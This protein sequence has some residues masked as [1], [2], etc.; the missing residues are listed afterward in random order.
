MK[1]WKMLVLPI[2]LCS[3]VQ[4]VQAQQT[5][6]LDTTLQAVIFGHKNNYHFGYSAAYAGDLNNDGYN[7]IIVGDYGYSESY[8][9]EDRGAA[10]IY[11]G[12]SPMDSSADFEI[13]GKKSQSQLGYCVAAAGDINN[14]GYADVLI[15]APANDTPYVSS[16]AYI[17]YGGNTGIDFTHY[18]SLTGYYGTTRYSLASAGD[19]N[20]DGYDDIIVRGYSAASVSIYY[21]GADGISNKTPKTVIFGN[22]TKDK[23]GSAV[24]SAGDINNDGYADI[25]VSALGVNVL[26][27]SSSQGAVYLYLGASEAINTVS[28]TTIYG[29]WYDA[30][31]GTSVAS[32]G[33]VNG[34]GYD[35]VIM[36]EG[37]GTGHAYLF[38]GG[39]SGLNAVTDTMQWRTG[40][41]FGN[42]VAPAGDLDGD[43]FNDIL[44]GAPEYSLS[45]AING[46]V[47]S[48]Y[49]SSDGINF[50]KG[51][52]L[53]GLD[54]YDDYGISIAGSADFDNDGRLDILV[55]ADGANSNY[56][57]VYIYSSKVTTVGINN[58]PKPAPVSFRL[59]Q[60]YPNPFNPATILS[61]RLPHT[62][63]VT[64]TVYDILGREIKT[65]VN[66]QQKAGTHKLLFDGSNL[67]SGLYLYKMKAGNFVQTRKM[68]LIK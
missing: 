27:N 16:L 47:H 21:G 64:L 53:F 63:H 3:I 19:V 8:S 18:D 7:D 22:S 28:D 42:S 43:G 44:I 52:S 66:S 62:S 9:G 14:D 23:F 54:R 38:Y 39:Q 49:G 33:D 48:F 41:K 55:A 25:L 67:S 56:G 37:W 36:G 24:A 46:A 26:G 6:A 68:F 11:L 30:H 58:G 50:N 20:G 1:S 10:Y 15:G 34:D 13:I 57:A 31:L 40:D 32:A 4:Q 29:S 12:G 5:G 61:Y 65:L 51:D 60:N 35:D 59:N 2:L 17:Y 45:G